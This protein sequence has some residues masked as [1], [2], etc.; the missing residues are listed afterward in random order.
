MQVTSSSNPEERKKLILALALGALAIIFLWWALI[1]FGGSSKPTARSSNPAAPSQASRT[2]AN[3]SGP[4]T[5]GEIKAALLEQLT[6]I[7]FSY[8]APVVSEAKRNIFAYHEK[9]APTP[10]LSELPTPT[11]TPTPPLLL[12]TVSPSNVYARTDDFTLEA[13]GD[14]FT[15]GLRIT[16]DGRELETRYISPQ[17][18][19][20]S[21]NALIIANPGARQVV[22]R[23]IDGKVYSN[24]G[25]LN[26]SPPPTPNYSYI[27][28]IGYPRYIDTAILKDKGSREILNVQRGDVLGGRFRVTSISEKEVVFV[29]STLKIKHT[30]HF[31]SDT[32]KSIGPQARPTPKVDAEDDEP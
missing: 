19:S 12:A 29:D 24:A 16:I 27:G 22:V 6:P 32:E 9:P 5:P 26:V 28:I 7:D 18:L 25:V 1:G 2:A 30:L 11:P 31:S 4:Q 23:S 3:Q 10:G 8:G 13:T 20:A 15:P 14:K 21:V 17:Q